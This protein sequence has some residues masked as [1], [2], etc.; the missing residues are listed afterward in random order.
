MKKAKIISSALLSIVICTGIVCAL[1][2]NAVEAPT[3][4]EQNAVEE[5]SIDIRYP[6]PIDE[7]DAILEAEG[8]ILTPEVQK[9]PLQQSIDE[10]F[11]GDG[12]K[13][14]EEIAAGL[15]KLGI[16]TYPATSPRPIEEIDAELE[17]QGTARAAGFPIYSQDL[18]YS[19]SLGEIPAG[20][21]VISTYYFKPSGNTIE[22]LCT[23]HAM[24]NPGR[25]TL[26]VTLYKENKY[27]I[28]AD[29][30][31]SVKSQEITLVDSSEVTFPLTFANLDSDMY[32]YCLRFDNTTT[33]TNKVISGNAVVNDA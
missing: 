7:L 21:G 27:M 31:Q 9:T 2:A 1:T 4:S 15:E 25:K 28:G 16:T 32:V 17:Q 3:V 13:T 29:A 10:V 19:I 24:G 33:G 20:K 23:L 5:T 11:Y 12:I 18:P 14:S 8:A 6:M 26:R 22:V 30:W